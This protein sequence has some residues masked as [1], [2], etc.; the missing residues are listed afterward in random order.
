[1][2][3]TLLVSGD[4][5]L[6]P[7]EIPALRTKYAAVAGDWESGAIAHTCARNR[8]RVLIL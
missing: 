3:R 1:V 2:C 8:Q 6:V 5:D 7:A 4:R